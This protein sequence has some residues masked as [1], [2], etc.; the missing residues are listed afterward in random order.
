ML[1]FGASLRLL[2][3]VGVDHI[4]A[5]ILNITDHLCE[6]VSEMGLRIVS[7]RDGEERSGIVSF[8]LPGADLTAVRRHCC[9]QGVALACRAG[10]IR[11]SPHGYN[12][13]EDVD[14][15]IAALKSFSE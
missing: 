10:R 5:S 6:R 11:V 1:G 7:P 13:Q 14:R 9:K 15:L 2:Q 8:E 3:D 4:A 12:N